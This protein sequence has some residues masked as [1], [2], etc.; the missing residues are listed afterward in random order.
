MKNDYNKESVEYCRN[1]LELG[2]IDK[3]EGVVL[4]TNCG[5]T[6]FTTHASDIFEY[7]ELKEKA[8]KHIKS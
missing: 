7:L 5:A 3:K 8:N 1:C 2:I 6:N 4:C